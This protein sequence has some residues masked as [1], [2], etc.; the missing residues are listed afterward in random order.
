MKINLNNSISKPIW[1]KSWRW[2]TSL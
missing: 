2:T 1:N